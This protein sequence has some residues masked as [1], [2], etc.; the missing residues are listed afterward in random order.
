MLGTLINSFLPRSHAAG[1]ALE[2]LGHPSAGLIGAMNVNGSDMPMPVTRD[3]ALT[4][5][6]VWCA[7]RIISETLATLPCIEYR[8]TGDDSRERATDDPRYFLV[9]DQPHQEIDPVTFFE[10]ETSHMVMTGNCYSRIVFD[11]GRMPARLEP[12]M[13]EKVFVKVDGDR[14][15]YELHDPDENITSENMLHVKGLGGD[16]VKGWSVITYG[17]QSIAA[18]LSGMKRVNQQF[19]SA[20][21][22]SGLLKVPMRLDK[23]GREALRREWEEVHKTAGKIGIVHGGMEFTSTALM[24][25]HDS[26]FLELNVLSIRDI[27]RLFRVPL[28]MLA[29]LENASVRANIEQQGIE[30]IVYSMAPWIIR[31]QQCLNRKLLRPE[32]RGTLYFEFLIDALL[33]GDTIT[34]Y[35]AHALARQWGFKSVNEIRSEENMN[36][37]EGGDVYLQPANMVPAGTVPETITNEMQNNLAKSLEAIVNASKDMVQ[38]V[39]AGY[40]SIQEAMQQASCDTLQEIKGIR[41]DRD[42]IRRDIQTLGKVQVQGWSELRKERLAVLL[43]I[44]RAEVAKAAK[45]QQERGESFLKWLDKFYDSHRA[46]M[47]ERVGELAGPW[48]QESYL[49]LLAATDGDASSFSSRIQQVLDNWDS[50]L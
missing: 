40:V 17:A 44:E 30:F 39:Q 13:P 1:R 20:S 7:N 43:K 6:A 3:T 47:T 15:A 32:E 18:G 8:K 31:W 46:K 25:N 2:S 10:V 50:R 33:R 35:Q 37:V 14:L 29:D 5:A 4:F 9:H 42:D 22:P 12:R 11:Q 48:C 34:R 27:A 36:S 28:H 16:G 41:A 23:D 19:N 26:Q 38:Q 45:R 21:V 24:S 49:Q